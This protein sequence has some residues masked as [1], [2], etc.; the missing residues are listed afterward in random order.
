[1]VAHTDNEGE[2]IVTN[3]L[4]VAV[5][6]SGPAGFYAV[7][8]LSKQEGGT[9]AVDLFDRLP[10]PYG[11]VRGGVAPDH[12]KIKAVIRQ[13]EKIAARPGFR[14]FGNVTFGKDLTLDE[15]LAHYHQVLFTT[16]A[17]SDRRMG[18]PGEDLPGSYPATIFVGWYNG[19]PD[20]RHLQ[21]DLSNVTQVAV[22]GNGN[23]AMDVVRVIGRSVDTLAKTDIAEYALA[24]L[25]KSAVQ[26]VYLLGRRGGAQAAFTNPEIRELA[27][28]DEEGTDLVV[29]ADE[30]TPDEVNR[31]FLDEHS[32]EPTHRRNIDTLLGQIPKGE[33]H[34]TKK[35]RARFF[36]SP[37]EVLGTDRVEGLRLE[38]NRLVRDEKGNYKAQGAGVYEEIP[39]QMVFRSIG[40]KGHPLPHVPFDERDGIIPNRDGRVLDPSTKAVVPRVYVAGWIKRGP[41]GVIGTNKPDSVATVEA[42]LA[43]AAQ[44]QSA[45]GLQLDAEAIPALLARKNVQAVTFVGWKRI[46]QVEIADGKKIGKPREKLTTIAELLAAAHG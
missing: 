4:R 2:D 25:R 10:T 15:V 28:L 27:E 31:Q 16:G 17:E 11:L 9:I 19:H 13:Y 14:F 23:V 40:Y 6:G 30:V 24:V 37:V 46:D 18:I 32:D 35:I 45:N 39:C 5:F 12:Q 34:Q 1:M 41:S 20:Y 29:R 38:K 8:E 22:I 26:E 42:M 36:V 7:D 43:D 3:P 33:G 44:A 21:F